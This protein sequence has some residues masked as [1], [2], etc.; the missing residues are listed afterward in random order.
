MVYL[1][2]AEKDI[3]WYRK[4]SRTSGVEIEKKFYCSNCATIFQV[5]MEAFFTCV[6]DNVETSHMK[7]AK[8]KTF[9]QS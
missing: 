6:Q 4:K 1:F 3:S 7:P 9:K 5:K 2:Y 8:I